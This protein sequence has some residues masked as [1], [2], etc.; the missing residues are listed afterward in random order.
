M[1]RTARIAALGVTAAA[2]AVA[3]SPALAALGA[4]VASVDRDR[5]QLKAALSTVAQPSY[6]VHLLD[7]PGG[8]VVREYVDAAGLVFAVTWNGPF[9]PDLS[10]TLGEYFA[11]YLS[12]ERKAGSSRSQLT[13][14]EPDLVIESNGRLRSFRG[15]AYLPGALPAGVTLEELR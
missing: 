11:R 14:A 13:I 15:R 3:G 12:A 7:L 5:V 2:L 8:T 6:S 4:N 9:K 10:Q 1:N